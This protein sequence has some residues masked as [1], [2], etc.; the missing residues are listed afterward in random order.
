MVCSPKLP[1][2]CVGWSSKSCKQTVFQLYSGG[3]AAWK[4]AFVQRQKHD[5]TLLVSDHSLLERPI[6]KISEL[7][8]EA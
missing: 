6:T 2:W 7:R 1:I 5:D 8:P 3:A 4:I